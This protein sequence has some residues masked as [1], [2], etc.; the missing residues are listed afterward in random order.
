MTPHITNLALAFLALLAIAQAAPASPPPT[1]DP[2]TSIGSTAAPAWSKEAIF[3]LV[4][5]LV[6]L[7]GILVMVILSSA[8]V[9]GWL[10]YP[11]KG[12]CA[13]SDNAIVG[14]DMC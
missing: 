3:T 7:V 1:N 2:Q 4:G 5:I 12:E 14:I 9:R 13:T 11:F 10:Y 8:R 6:A